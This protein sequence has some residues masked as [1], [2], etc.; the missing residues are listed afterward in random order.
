MPGMRCER[1][2]ATIEW[3][4]LVLLASLVLTALVTAVPVS[5]GRAF[6]GF[7]SERIFC[8]VGGGGCREGPGAQRQPGGRPGLVSFRAPPPEDGAGAGAGAGV[9]AAAKRR[10]AARRFLFDK[11]KDCLIGATGAKAFEPFAEE[12]LRKESA[13]SVKNALRASKKGLRRAKDTVV[14]GKA[15]PGVVGCVGGMVGL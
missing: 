8:A 13:K 3:V 4:G 11:A 5:E 6:G 15:K 14:R 7:V 1:G 9:R 2:Q 10:G 12:L